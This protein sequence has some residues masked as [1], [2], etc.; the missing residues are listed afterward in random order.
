MNFQYKYGK[1]KI[2]IKGGTTK[3]NFVSKKTRL[4]SRDTNHI[5]R[6]NLSWEQKSFHC[7]ISLN[8]FPPFLIW[9]N[10]HR[11]HVQNKMGVYTSPVILI[12]QDLPLIIIGPSNPGMSC[13][14]N[15]NWRFGLSNEMSVADLLLCSGKRVLMVK[16]T[17]ENIP[18]QGTIN[19]SSNLWST[20]R[21]AS[22]QT[23]KILIFRG[24]RS[25]AF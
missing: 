14:R 15:E 22:D 10:L 6:S 2:I 20:S 19:R 11:N 17:A 25:L 13:E 1:L 16:R 7:E 5:F 23:A 12:F 8:F 21:Y 9:I 4:K 24:G 3:V 18:W